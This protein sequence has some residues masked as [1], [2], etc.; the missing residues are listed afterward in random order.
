MSKPKQDA[1]SGPMDARQVAV[2]VVALAKHLQSSGVAFLP[3]PDEVGVNKWT[4]RMAANRPAREDST[5]SVDSRAPQSPPASAE[6]GKA[7]PAASSLLVDVAETY[8][9][10]SLSEDQ[11]TI[12]LEVLQQQVAACTRCA[13]LVQ[14][15]TLT[16]FGEGSVTPRVAFFGEG[17]GADEDRSGRPFV[18]KAGQLLTKMIEACKMRREDVYILNTVKCRPPGNRNPEPEEVSNCREYF[19]QQLQILRP[20]YIVCL[21]AVASQALLRSKL[22]VGRLRGKFHQYFDS[23]V[24]VTYHPAYLLRNPSAKKAAWQDLQIMLRDAGLM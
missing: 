11:R 23:K 4:M 21:G 8:P 12:Q 6:T 17:P 20:E 10:D 2:Q 24:L 7:T 22:P 16:V 14:S 9:G 15:R 5:A 1:E 19:Q 3:N 18:G 13:Q